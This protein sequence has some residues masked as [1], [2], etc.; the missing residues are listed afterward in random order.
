M[1]DDRAQR[2]MQELFGLVRRIAPHA[3]AALVM[4][5]TAPGRKAS[6]ARS[7]SRPAQVAALRHRQLLRRRETLFES[8]LFGHVRGAFTGATDHKAGC[9]G[10]PTAVP[11]SSTKSASCPPASR[12]SCCAYSTRGRSSASVR[13]RRKRSTSGCSPRPTGTCA[14]TRRPR[15]SQGPVLPA[16]RGGLIVPPLRD[17]RDDIPYLVATFVREFATRSS[18]KSRA[19]APPRSGC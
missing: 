10:P 13:S 1:R 6:R 19:S 4:G 14:A 8:E 2:I 16:Q 18:G 11:S 7:T 3:R 17:R 5:E 15:V 12:P 9:S